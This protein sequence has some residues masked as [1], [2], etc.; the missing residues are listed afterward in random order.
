[1]APK[2]FKCE[3]CQKILASDRSLKN[4]SRNIHQ[5]GGGNELIRLD[6]RPT[7][8]DAPFKTGASDNDNKHSDNI[9]PV[10]VKPKFAPPL[11][12][13]KVGGSDQR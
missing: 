5:N 11:N 4:H 7:N 8:K 10:K 12:P 2:V 9:D 6:P 1:M 13:I 3:I